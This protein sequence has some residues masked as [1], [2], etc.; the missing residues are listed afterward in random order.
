MLRDCGSYLRVTASGLRLTR[1]FS[2]SDSVLNRA[3]VEAGYDPVQVQTFGGIFVIDKKQIPVSIE[4]VTL[5][6]IL[7]LFG[8][9][10][11]DSGFGA[12]EYGFYNAK[13]VINSKGEKTNYAYKDRYL[14]YFKDECVLLGVPGVC[15]LQSDSLEITFPKESSRE[16][17]YLMGLL[18]S[19]ESSSKIVVRRTGQ[20]E[21]TVRYGSA[22]HW[23]VLERYALT[24]SK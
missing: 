12:V 21:V 23:V 7:C 9:G 4:L 24:G 11:K 14:N 16:I 20:N 19:K 2:V 18:D 8:C 3:N 17:F 1:S 22:E 13:E 15:K 10:N 5:I 6:G